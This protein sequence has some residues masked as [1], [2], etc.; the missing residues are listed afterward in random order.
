MRFWSRSEGKTKAVLNFGQLTGA[1]PS[2]PKFPMRPPSRK[3]HTWWRGWIWIHFGQ[4]NVILSL[5]SLIVGHN[6]CAPCMEDRRGRPVEPSWRRPTDKKRSEGPRP[7]L[8]DIQN[9]WYYLMASATNIKENVD[10]NRR[11]NCNI[12]WYEDNVNIAGKKGL[13]SLFLTSVLLLHDAF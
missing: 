9:D 13:R 6:Y 4:E 10:N 12:W 8:D 2:R 11:I 5:D 3:N 1:L 7:D